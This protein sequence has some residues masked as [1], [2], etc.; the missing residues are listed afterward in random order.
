MSRSGRDRSPKRKITL[1]NSP[2][3]TAPESTR[4]APST[5]SPMFVSAGSTSCT[6]SNHVR[7]VSART[8]CDRTSSATVES[9]SVSP[10][11]RPYD[12]TSWTPSK[13]S[14]T[15]AEKRPSVSC[16]AVK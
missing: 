5:T 15:A 2:I 14:W 6:A 3:V 10:A 12:L 8:R 11:S 9:R 1:L 4:T 7:S 13:L 16:A